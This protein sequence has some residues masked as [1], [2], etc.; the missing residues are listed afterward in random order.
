M[1]NLPFAAKIK[2]LLDILKKLDQLETHE[3]PEDHVLLKRR[4]I[5]RNINKETFDT[6]GTITKLPSEN[7]GRN[8]HV[9]LLNL[10]WQELKPIDYQQRLDYPI[11]FQQKAKENPDFIHNL[12]MS[13]A[14]HF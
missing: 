10:V 9:P 5:F 8:A 1:R 7:F 2:A 4:K 14:A 12:I 13:D 3:F 6:A 11:Y